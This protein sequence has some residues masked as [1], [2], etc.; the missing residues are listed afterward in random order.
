MPE[1][2]GVDYLTA[3]D[4]ARL[5]NVS[6]QTV[7]RWIGRELIPDYI[8]MGEKARTRYLIP[9]IALKDFVPPGSIPGMPGWSAR[10]KADVS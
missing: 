6:R 2:N 9:L 7:Y 10:D 4:V 1:I 8:D 3:P 5:F